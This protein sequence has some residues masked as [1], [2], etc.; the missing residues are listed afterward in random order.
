MQ[1]DIS[2]QGVRRSRKKNHLKIKASAVA[3]FVKR[4]LCGITFFIIAVVSVLTIIRPSRTAKSVQ[5]A[6]GVSYE[7]RY[8][9]L[10]RPE[11]IHITEV[12]LADPNISLLVTPSANDYIP[13]RTTTSFLAE[14]GATVAV[15]GA[16]FGPQSWDNPIVYYPHAGDNVKMRGQAI[17]NS[18][19]YSPPIRDWGVLCISKGNVITFHDQICPDGTEQALSGCGFLAKDGVVNLTYTDGTQHSLHSRTGVGINRKTKKM[20]L[21]VVDGRQWY[22]SEGISRNEFAVLMLD[23]GA[24][25]A[26]ELD[27]GGSTTMAALID[28]SVTLMNSPTHT[29]IPRRERP[30]GN[31]LGVIVKKQ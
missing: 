15:N 29:G 28:G 21:V 11:V 27:G 18:K 9:N 22:Y 1:V 6:R 30:V 24:T 2:P 19:E 16:L 8:V 31:H 26:M 3:L 17:S 5:L 23:L 25:D 4:S 7:R 20:W 13:A 14:F 10:V 12:D